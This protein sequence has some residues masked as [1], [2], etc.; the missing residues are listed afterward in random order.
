MSITKLILTILLLAFP[1]I[2]YLSLL[3]IA[4]KYYADGIYETGDSYFKKLEKSDNKSK[5]VIN[6]ME[7]VRRNKKFYV[8]RKSNETQTIKSSM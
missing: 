3:L 1:L 5:K 8:H 6:K 2:I 7:E 4:R